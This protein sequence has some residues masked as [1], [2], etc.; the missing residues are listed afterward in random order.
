[1]NMLNSIWI[2]IV[3]LKLGG[4]QAFAPDRPHSREINLN[5]RKLITNTLYIHLSKW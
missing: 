2:H 3:H 5:K 4:E 1:M